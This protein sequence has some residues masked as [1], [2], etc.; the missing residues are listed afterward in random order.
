MRT[1]RYIGPPPREFGS[2][3]TVPDAA[4]PHI[5]LAGG[6]EDA[7]DAPTPDA[8]ASPDDGLPPEVLATEN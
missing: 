5:L 7:P 8:P 6:Y 1:L 3:V 2:L 4:A